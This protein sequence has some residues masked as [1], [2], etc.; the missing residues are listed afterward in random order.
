MH[1]N[2]LKK[3]YRRGGWGGSTVLKDFKNII[4][5]NSITIVLVS[6]CACQKLSEML[7]A[8]GVGL[9]IFHQEYTA[10]VHG[11]LN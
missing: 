10:S 3:R 1:P 4:I 5:T 9:V 8:S 6:Y 7:S 11:I 2:Q